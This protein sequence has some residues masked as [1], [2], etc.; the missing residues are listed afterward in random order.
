MRARQGW[1]QA[2]PHRS[3]WVES[4]RR[5]GGTPGAMIGSMSVEPAVVSPGGPSTRPKSAA[6]TIDVAK[7]SKTTDTNPNE[8]ERT[9]EGDNTLNQL[10]MVSMAF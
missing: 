2:S 6:V 1:L 5:P 9:S 4:G 8:G 3:L 7:M 10:G